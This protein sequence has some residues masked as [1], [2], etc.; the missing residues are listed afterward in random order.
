MVYI[1]INFNECNG[2]VWAAELTVGVNSFQISLFS[3]D[4]GYSL[5]RE[6]GMR[7][8][9][10][11]DSNSQLDSI[12]NTLV[13]IEPNPITLPNYSDF[14]GI[15][16]NMTYEEV[17]S[18]VGFPHEYAG[19]LYGIQVRYN[20]VEGEIYQVYF[21]RYSDGKLIVAKTR[22]YVPESSTTS[23]TTN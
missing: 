2:I 21:D 8:S 5:H 10:S 16:E 9:L 3:N 4:S 19:Y 23:N 20:T 18:K 1:V 12:F 6:K 7:K 15:A 11:S 22:S 14:E 17:V 13:T